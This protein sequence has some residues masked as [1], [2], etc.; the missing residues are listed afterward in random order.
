MHS[1]FKRLLGIEKPVPVISVEKPQQQVILRGY[2]KADNFS[3][4]VEGNYHIGNNTMQQIIID[5]LHAQHHDGAQRVLIYLINTVGKSGKLTTTTTTRRKVMRERTYNKLS[6]QPSQINSLVEEYV[7]YVE[8]IGFFAGEDPLAL[9][10]TGLNE[11]AQKVAEYGKKADYDASFVLSLAFP[12]TAQSCGFIKVSA[13]HMDGAVEL[14]SKTIRLD[15][16]NQIT[17][18]KNSNKSSK[19]GGEPPVEMK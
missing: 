19:D 3:Y 7:E 16:T 5:T 14:S 15:F 17:P 8:S 6:I 10:H 9:I 18:R 1:F 12:I 2:E 11:Y 4:D 13:V